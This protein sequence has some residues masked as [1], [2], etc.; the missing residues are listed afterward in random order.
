[1]RHDL[2]LRAI[3]V[4]GSKHS[5]LWVGEPNTRPNNN[6]STTFS[7]ENDLIDDFYVEKE[8]KLKKEVI[9]IKYGE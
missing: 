3:T 4:Y 9:T 2:I 7:H 6:I 5:I 1:M 8:I